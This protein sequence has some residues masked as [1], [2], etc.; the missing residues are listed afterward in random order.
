MALRKEDLHKLIDDNPLS[1][2]EKKQL[3][4]EGYITGEEARVNSGY[5]LIY[6]REAVKFLSRQEKS[7][8]DR[9]AH[10]LRGLLQVR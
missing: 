9:I 3:E 6:H 4:S 7:T 8:Q 1:Q 5:K 2:E 10:G